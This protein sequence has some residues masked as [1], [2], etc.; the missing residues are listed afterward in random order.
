VGR[1]KNGKEGM[2][3]WKKVREEGEFR[4]RGKPQK[5]NPEKL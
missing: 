1:A 5:R 4:K 2:G 3:N